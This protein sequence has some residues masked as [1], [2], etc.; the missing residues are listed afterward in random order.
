MDVA[1]ARDAAHVLSAEFCPQRSQSPI[2]GENFACTLQ[3]EMPPTLSAYMS[4]YGAVFAE[5]AD[6]HASPLVSC[7]IRATSSFRGAMRAEVPSAA[8]MQTAP[9]AGRL[10]YSTAQCR[11]RALPMS[12]AA[13]AT[14]DIHAHVSLRYPSEV[15]LWRQPSVTTLEYRVLPWAQMGRLW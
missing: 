10:P 5:H 7:V 9:L 2:L 3:I 13:F 8:S 4:T 14:P 1:D 11:G 12:L 6:L 15:S